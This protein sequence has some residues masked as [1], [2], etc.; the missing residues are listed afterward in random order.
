LNSVKPFEAELR[1]KLK[2]TY[3]VEKWAMN[4][5]DVLCLNA[6]VLVPQ[7]SEP[8]F[9]VDNLEVTFQTNYL[10]P[11][12]VGNCVLDLL[13]PGGRV[14]VATSGLHVGQTLNFDGMIDDESG[15]AKKEFSMIDDSEFHFKQCYTLSKVCNVAY[16]LELNR[17]LQ[18][19]GIVANCFSPGL[20]T[21][22]GLFRHQCYSGDSGT[23]VQNKHVLMK[24]KTVEWGAGALVFMVLADMSGRR[25][26]EFWR[27]SNST[28]GAKAIYGKEFC[29]CAIS[30]ESISQEKRTQ[31]WRLSCELAGIPCDHNQIEY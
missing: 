6:A 21:T 22:S 13:N 9:T 23:F 5:I 27:D 25:G 11:F 8:E 10:T 14:V 30:E 28:L 3:R 24:E 2:E 17:I 18:P 16:C 31:L 26:G 29:P 12:L 15:S 20:M 1:A 4:G 7:G 19:R